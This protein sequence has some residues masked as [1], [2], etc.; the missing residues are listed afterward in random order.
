M[1]TETLTD[2]TQVLAILM[3]ANINPADIQPVPPYHT[4]DGFMALWPGAWLI[5]TNERGNFTL[6][7]IEDASKEEAYS[8]FDALSGSK[9]GCRPVNARLV[10]IN[11]EPPE[12]N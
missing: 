7:L 6:T 11:S 12:R 8:H 9:P 2:Q 10:T 5:I 4:C 3:A 1:T